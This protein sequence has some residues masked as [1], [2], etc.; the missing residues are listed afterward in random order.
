[1]TRWWPIKGLAGLGS[2]SL[3]LFNGI[4]AHV[5]LGCGHRFIG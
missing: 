4:E 1:M 5:S 3:D 2:R